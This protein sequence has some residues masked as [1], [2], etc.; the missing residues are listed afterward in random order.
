MHNVKTVELLK[1]IINI[2]DAPTCFGLQRNH[3]QG[4]KASA[5]LK[6]EELVQC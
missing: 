1:R 4:A 6:L 5:E 2:E 3:H